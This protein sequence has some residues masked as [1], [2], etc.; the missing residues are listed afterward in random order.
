MIAPAYFSSAQHTTLED[1]HFKVPILS[2]ARANGIPATEV[3]E[4]DASRQSNRVSA[5]VSGFAGTTRISLNDN[6]LKRCS[7]PGIEATMGHEMGHYVLNHQ[8]KGCAQRTGV[9]I[10][11]HF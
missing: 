1:P 11:L 7:L 6:L 9:V 5:N 10:T 2:L 3:Y 8:F 4:F